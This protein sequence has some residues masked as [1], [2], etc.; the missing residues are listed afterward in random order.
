[1][2]KKGFTLV[3]VISVI[4]ILAVLILILYPT[5]N[6]LIL[7]SKEN[8]KT[9]NIEAYIKAGEEYY[10]S[11]LVDPDKKQMLGKNI[12]DQLNIQNSDAKGEV[13]VDFNGD[14][15]L[16]LVIDDKCYIKK[17]SDE[18]TISDNTNACMITIPVTPPDSCFSYEDI[19]G[20]VRILSYLC[21]NTYK[22]YAQGHYVFNTDGEFTEITLPE[23]LGGKKVVSVASYAFSNKG[24]NGSGYDMER[25][26]GIN[27]LYIPYSLKIE[28][29]AFYQ[30]DLETVI[31]SDD[32]VDIGNYAFL[33]NHITN[34]NIPS[35][36]V[37][38]PAGL[39]STNS[40]T[41]IKI[42]NNIISIG[43]NAFQNN[44][45]ETVIFDNKLES[46]ELYAF[47]SNKIKDLSFPASLR[48]IGNSAFESNQI[49]TIKMSNGITTIG[50][51][52][53]GKNNI[54]ALVLPDSINEI[55]ASAFRENKITSLKLPKNIKTIPDSSFAYN[56]ISEVE[57][58]EG[59][60]VIQSYAFSSCKLQEITIP[61]S[62]KEIYDR[63]F[64]SN[65]LSK[66]TIKGKKSASDFIHYDEKAFYNNKDV[67][68]N[69][70][71]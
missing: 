55:G 31:L 63:A 8:V 6:K 42:P 66:V 47:Y 27:K 18:V 46:I 53:F 60:E 26:S 13:I 36:L 1:M 32:I 23:N 56:F 64:G 5:V 48:T 69:W 45:I 12:I 20:G 19:E 62:V 58:P 29:Y 11:A 41:S 44:Q 17:D 68:I 52:S 25:K 57:L 37:N 51:E 28:D 49:E 3:E 24:L 50:Y 21:G 7:A 70:E 30:G 34:M 59:L 16:A 33:G 65:N 39:F 22:E 71:Q 54:K 61:S 4:I 43:A 9:R 15:S 67:I 35:K 2:N 38:I 40:L 14:V 10:V